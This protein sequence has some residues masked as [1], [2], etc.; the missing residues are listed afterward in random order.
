M[1]HMYIGNG[2]LDQIKPPEPVTLTVERLYEWCGELCW[3]ILDDLLSDRKDLHERIKK[4]K[5]KRG[6]KRG[7]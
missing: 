5:D 6:H 2:I 3:P 1:T 4:F 7:D